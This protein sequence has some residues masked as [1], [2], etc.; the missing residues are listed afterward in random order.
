MFDSP[1]TTFERFEMHL[2]ELN[3]GTPAP[4]PTKH[5]MEVVV[6]VKEGKLR[7]S[8]EGQEHLLGPGA[9][10]FMAPNALH[11]FANVG[12][13][14]A[15][16]YVVEVETEATQSPASGPAQP[17]AKPRIGSTVYDC[18]ALPK[19]ETKNGF[20]CPIVTAPTATLDEFESHITTLNPGKTLGSLTDLA[21]EV[22]VIKSGLVDVSIKGVTARLG[23]GSFYF[24]AS[25]DE[26]SVI[27][28]GD[29]PAS[30][31]ILKFVSKKTP[32]AP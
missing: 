24:Q 21:D 19:Q 31:Q 28:V 29:T 2:T 18:E 23:A 11:S 8:L 6:L 1:T 12:N 3:P 27:N 14:L 10:V 7:L 13:T 32:H 25:R 22:I 15:I 20:R 16:Y 17:G 5:P 26:H 30:Y 4:A 9:L